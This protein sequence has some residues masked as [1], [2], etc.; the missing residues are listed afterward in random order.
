MVINEPTAKVENFQS[1]NNIASADEVGINGLVVAKNI[2]ITRANRIV[3]RDGYVKKI[4]GQIIAMSGD[5][6]IVLFIADNSLM[7][8][9]DDLVSAT[10][11]VTGV[12]NSPVLSVCYAHNKLYWSN[13]EQIGSIRQN[14]DISCPV[15]ISIPTAPI[16]LAVEGGNMPKGDYI[17]AYTYFT[18][19]GEEGPASSISVI[20]NAELGLKFLNLDSPINCNNITHIGIYLTQKNG[21]VLYRA[22]VIPVG[23][24][25]YSYLNN[26]SELNFQLRSQYL[27][28]LPAGHFLRYF[29][30]RLLVAKD[31]YLFYSEAY[32]LELYNPLGNF[33]AFNFR[34]T[35]VGVSRNGVFVTT[36]DE[37]VFLAGHDPAKWEYIVVAKYGA[38]EGT[39]NAVDGELIGAEGVPNNTEVL[40]WATRNGLVIG[41]DDGS[42]INLTAKYFHFDGNAKKGTLVL[43]RQNGQNHIITITS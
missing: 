33:V 13:N 18:D 36:L 41:L 17:S 10:V 3:R 4:D 15:G 31:N 38:I 12:G 32:N 16:I 37:T 14:E 23:S 6:N 27:A 7:R 26:T 8:L 42:I 34:I 40:C 24:G 39:M 19:G 1:L 30:G 35:N 29:R 5:K 21:E 28:N 43:R 11:M 9:N 22:K 20:R 25:D 2:D